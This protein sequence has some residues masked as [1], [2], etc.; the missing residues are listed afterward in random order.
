MKVVKS[1]TAGIVA[2]LIIAGCSGSKEEAKKET[3]KEETKSVTA[4]TTAAQQSS[5]FATAQPA[6]AKHDCEE[7]DKAQ[8]DAKHNENCNDCGDKT[9]ITEPAAANLKAV[10][11]FTVAD[12]FAKTAELNG[13]VV[14]VKGDVVKVSNNIMG[15]SWVHIQ[16]GT[17][18]E[19]TNDI[20]F[21]SP[22]ATV[23]KGDKVTAKGI[24]AMNK[25]FGYGYFYKAIVEGSVFKK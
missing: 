9:K 20:I 23:V 6:A 7:C 4:E 11:T 13:K 17:G 2:A 3:P 19:G 14:E 25:D 12:L 18:A 24:L 15:R 22:N 16:D 5:A 1:I 8:P 21:T 10:G